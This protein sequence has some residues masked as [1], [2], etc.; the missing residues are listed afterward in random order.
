M[1]EEQAKKG[2]KDLIPEEKKTVETK[3]TIQEKEFE[4]RGETVKYLVCE[5]EVFGQKI[6]FEPTEKD[7]RLCRYLLDLNG[8]TTP[9]K[10]EED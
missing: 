3:L 4:S 10:E 2:V 7:A 1:A 6:R 9:K 5:A 8:V